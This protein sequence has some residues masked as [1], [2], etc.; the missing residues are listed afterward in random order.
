MGTVFDMQAFYRW[1]AE[2]S[3]KELVQRHSILLVFIKNVETVSTRENAQFH[4]RKIEEEMLVR[5]LK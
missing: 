2:A 4:L 3:D 5:A 1:L